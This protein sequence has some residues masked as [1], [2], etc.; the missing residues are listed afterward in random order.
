M[1]RAAGRRALLL[2][3]VVA[4]LLLLPYGWA[5]WQQMPPDAPARIGQIG[6][7]LNAPTASWQK[8]I[9]P[10]EWLLA[11]QLVTGGGISS[12]VGR[13]ETAALWW[14]LNRT[15]ISP[16][17]L[18][19]VGVGIVGQ[20]FQLV[21]LRKNVGARLLWPG[22]SA[23]CFWGFNQPNSICNIG[24]CCCR[25]RRYFSPW[26]SQPRLMYWRAGYK[27]TGCTLAG[28]VAATVMLVW[29]G[30]YLDVQS[31]V[32]RRA[33]G[34]TLR[35]WQQA[36]SVARDKP[37]RI[38]RRRC[39]A[40]HG[41]DPGYESEPAVVATLLG[42]PPFARFV[43]PRRRQLC[44]FPTTGPASTFGPSTRADRSPTAT[45]GPAHR[46][47][48]ACRPRCGAALSHSALCRS[49]V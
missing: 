35:G 10:A 40:V 47:P 46:H 43:A 15:L 24:R 36:L 30:S 7:Q 9:D 2:G 8:L 28:L 4:L 38:K 26:G 29:V 22:A 41:V 19:L 27:S 34:V 20:A 49:K 33:S 21:T 42:S 1:P 45:V 32:A 5:L 12:I 37:P 16:L 11:R 44:S 23:L 39:V 18:L 3:A 14:Q 13:M 6:D 17:L 31:I 25:C 48:T